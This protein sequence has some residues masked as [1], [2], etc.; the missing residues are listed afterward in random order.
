VSKL[1]CYG[2]YDSNDNH[3][4]TVVASNCKEAKEIGFSSDYID[5]YSWIEVSAKW[6]KEANIEGFETGVV[7]DQ[8]CLKA[9]KQ[10]IFSAQGDGCE[11]CDDYKECKVILDGF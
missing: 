7:S 6:K 8:N 1:R 11:Y 10:G 5:D 4:C 3:L 9:V 2:I